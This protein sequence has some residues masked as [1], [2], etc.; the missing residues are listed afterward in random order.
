MVEIKQYEQS[1]QLAVEKF[2]ADCFAVL[3][4]GLDLSDRHSDIR[5]IGEEYMR[6]GMFWCAFEGGTLIGTVAVRQIDDNGE[7]AELKRFYV[8]PEFQGKGFGRLLFKTALDFAKASE[9]RVIR[10][11]TQ[12]NRSASRHLFES[13]GF[14]LI[15]KYNQNA[16][17]ELFYELWLKKET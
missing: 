10:L 17:A 11:D 2:Y 7:I 12:K 1:M 16:Y 15:E 3:G 9:F 4:W 5:N 14:R 6:G 8:L 13:H